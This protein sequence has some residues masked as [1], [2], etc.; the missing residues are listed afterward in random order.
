MRIARKHNLQG[1]IGEVS[2][3]TSVW[4]RPRA[5]GRSSSN[6]PLYLTSLSGASCFESSGSIGISSPK[7][8]SLPLHNIS[9][10]FHCRRP[11]RSSALVY[12]QSLPPAKQNTPKALPRYHL[13]VGSAIAIHGKS[14]CF[15]PGRLHRHSI[16]TAFRMLLGGLP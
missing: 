10:P 1:L 7:H 15:R 3:L 2:N 16:S 13:A 9:G 14:F 6:A 8:T 11:L 4:G 12:P 5:F